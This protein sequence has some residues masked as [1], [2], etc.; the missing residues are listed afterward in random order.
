M[1]KFLFTIL[2]VL[3]VS[4]SVAN[5][6][7][8]VSPS[9]NDSNSG[10]ISSPVGTLNRALSMISPGDE[11]VM[12][13]GRYYHNSRIT[14]NT[15][16]SGNASR[17]T[18]L[19]AYENEVP[20]LDFWAQEELSGRDGLRLLAS[21][22][23]IIGIHVHGAGGNGFRI[24]GSYNI[25][26][27]CVAYRNRLTGIHIESR[28]PAPRASHNLIKNCDS[29]HNFNWRGRVGNMSDGFT[30][31]Y[32]IGPGN[33]FYGCRA[34]GNSDDGFDFWRARNTII[35]EKCWAFGNGDISV[36]ESYFSNNQT[37]L[38][39]LRSEFDG[40]GNGFKMGGDHQPGPHIVKRSMAFDNTGKGFDHNNNTG[41]MT[42][43]H[44][45]AY[46][47]DRN[48]VFPN[49]PSSGR[50][51]FQNNLSA[52]SRVI[53]Q[54]PS[55]A[56]LQ[57]NSWQSG[58]VTNSMFQSVNTSLARQPRQS[59]G[60]LPETTLFKLVDGSF[61]VNGGV[62]IGEPFSGTA[63][64]IGAYE[65]GVI[66]TP[67]PPSGGG[68]ISSQDWNFSA[69]PEYASNFS[70]SGS[71]SIAGATLYNGI[72]VDGMAARS[73]TIDGVSYTYNRRVKLNGTGQFNGHQPTDRVFAFDVPG[74][75]TITI[76]CQSAN[77]SQN[78]SLRIANGSNSV[79]HTIS[80][81]G[82]NLAIS[83]YEYT[84]APTTIYLYSPSSGVNLYHVRVESAEPEKF[85]LNVNA[86][87]GTVMPSDGEFESGTELQLN[88]IPD[89]GFV[90]SHWSGDI[91]GTN[92]PAALIIETDIN[93]T[94]H[95]VAANQGGGG[96]PDNGSALFDWNFSAMP[97]YASNFSVSGS[98]SI[99]GATLYNGIEVDGMAA[100]SVTMDGVSYTYNRRVK[101][102]GSGQFSGQQ[103]TGRVVAF[104]VP[105]DATITIVCQS[106]S[107]SQN[108]VLRIADG[109]NNVLH[110]VAA[111][112]SNLALS[113]YQYSGEATTIFLYSPD[114]GVNLYHVR[115]EVVNQQIANDWFFTGMTAY[116]SDFTVSGSQSIAGAV[117]YNGIEVD[118][119]SARSQ[120]VGDQTYT[121]TRRVKLNGTGQFNGQQPIGRVFA[122]D[123]TGNSRITIVCQSASSSSNRILNI[124]TAPNNIL[125]AI[126]APGANLQKSVYNYI[127]GAT[128]IYLFSPN[129]G[130]NLYHVR[131]ENIAEG[132]MNAGQ[133]VPT[134]IPDNRY[135]NDDIE[136]IVYYNLN[137]VI[138]GNDFDRL[139]PGI[140]IQLTRYKD[141]HVKSSKVIVSNR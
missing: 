131:V 5:N 56:L 43:I 119:M 115:V 71:R 16:L 84:G 44:N 69:M 117:L 118:G 95:F 45:T 82:N 91:T 40:G 86:S 64:D 38:N 96:S 99:A 112:G 140:F 121:Y 125:Q 116:S 72:E 79:L 105:G 8:Y 77:S 90:F 102:N 103:P 20:I 54:T 28:D 57:G 52:N 128:T 123:V 9:G 93:A 21:Y 53:A 138:V 141:G 51:V 15:N 33:H 107:S 24:E 89:N 106:A 36:F 126:S 1:K 98:R 3:F 23:H 100:R 110:T 66:T 60:S 55:N 127:G 104:D 58:T 59:D 113:V 111:P 35:V 22:W 74:D 94:A 65:F 10:T 29:Y 42:F 76:V 63:P 122:F 78:R 14:I 67:P 4:L 12:R 37:Q 132:P 136:S 139:P 46:N 48:Y 62:D 26:E 85:L 34:W 137:G 13:G 49:N 7:I 75:V 87:N 81:P 124:A 133:N 108:R 97:E 129:S 17:R 50:T 30:A 61:L 47:N 31:K 135:A 27:N 39:R 18:V 6:T 130:V 25:L 11:I 70:V 80:A 68:N 83:V 101:L 32:D 109:S 41:A 114:S 19:R 120:D 92:N 2:S 73:A 134:F 88:A